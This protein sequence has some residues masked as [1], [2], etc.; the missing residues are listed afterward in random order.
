[1]TRLLRTSILGMASAAVIALATA[2]SAL[3]DG[4]G[5]GFDAAKAGNKTLT[6]L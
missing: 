1:M 2:T 5:S 6:L 4:L 3:A